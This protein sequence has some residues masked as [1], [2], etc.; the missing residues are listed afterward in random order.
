MVTISRETPQTSTSLLS[1]MNASDVKSAEANYQSFFAKDVAKGGSL[2]N[3]IVNG[4]KTVSR[5]AG[6]YSAKYVENFQKTGGVKYQPPDAAKVAD[7]IKKRGFSVD[8]AM[9]KVGYN[10]SKEQLLADYKNIMGAK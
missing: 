6:Q 8:D 9:K 3:Q 5:N 10:G 4:S 1:K 2:E 7:L